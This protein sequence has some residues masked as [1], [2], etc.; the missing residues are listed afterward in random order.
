MEHGKKK[1]SCIGS[2]EVYIGESKQRKKTKQKKTQKKQ[3][4]LLTAM[5]M[6]PAIEGFRW[7]QNG[8]W[9]EVKR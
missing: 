9:N 7:K 6:L 2:V 5:E 3:R 8:K 4:D 1:K